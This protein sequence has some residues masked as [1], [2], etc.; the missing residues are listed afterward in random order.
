M[1]RALQPVPRWAIYTSWLLSLVGLGLASYL[2]YEHF[3]VKVF[4]GC[5]LGG[6]FD[7]QKVTTS[8]Q[9]RVLGVPVAVLGLVNFLVF[10]VINSPLAWRIRNYWLHVARF[11]LSLG[12]MIFVLW[13]VYA[14]LLII[15]NVCIYCTGV[16]IVTFALF[17]V[18]VR[19]APA[20]L[21]WSESAAQ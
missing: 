8:P 21:G 19:V 11:V 10:S 3:A 7:C 12:G 18:L 5:S 15:D 20:Q 13:L 6:I 2:T 1:P 14:E 9:S 16:H 4:Q 17:V